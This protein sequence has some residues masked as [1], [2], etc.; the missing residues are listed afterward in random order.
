M[1]PIQGPKVAELR[2]QY[3]FLRPI[4]I[5]AGVYGK[6]KIPTLGS[7]WLLACRDDLSEDIVY[8]MLGVFI[9]SI[10]EL[11]KAQPAL[12]TVTPQDF[13]LT[14]IPLHP[15]AARFYREMELLK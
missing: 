3:P 1:A 12:L 9:N 4:T 14:P 6:E 2:S 8:R 15:G 7:N 11:A 5:P 13:A 10:E